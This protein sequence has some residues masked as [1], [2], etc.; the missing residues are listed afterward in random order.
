MTH[1]LN[2][3]WTEKPNQMN[4]P[5]PTLTKGEN[6]EKSPSPISWSIALAALLLSLYHKE[7]VEMASSTTG[8][9]GWYRG[10]VKSVS[11]GD[12][13]V[14]T[15]MVANKPGPPPEKTITLSSL[16]APRLWF[17]LFRW[18]LAFVESEITL[19]RLNNLLER[20]ISWN[21]ENTVVAQEVVHKI[22][23]T[24]Q[25]N[26]LS[27]KNR[28]GCNELDALVK[29][30]WWE[31]KPNSTRFL[32]FKAWNDICKPKEL[33]GSETLVWTICKVVVKFKNLV[34]EFHE[35]SYMVKTSKA[36]QER[37]LASAK[38]YWKLNI[39]AVFSNGKA[40]ITF[41]VR[42]SNGKILFLASR[43]I[44]CDFPYEAEIQAFAWALACAED[45]GWNYI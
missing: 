38:G 34:D 10:R 24:S 25:K 5:I 19:G 16:I 36:S 44:Q 22:D 32:T 4:G 45:K 43:S 29:T 17:C 28:G 12:C 6:S 20:I 33:G 35:A 13:L 15:A 31:A 1:T 3:K 30:F 2:S 39:D 42:D 23:R 18:E 37:W 11:S 40:S 9:T 8:A 14:I 21:A 26:S 27:L 41:V 7:A